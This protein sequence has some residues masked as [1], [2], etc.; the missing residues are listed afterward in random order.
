MERPYNPLSSALVAVHA[1]PPVRAVDKDFMEMIKVYSGEE[2]A[3]YTA[4]FAVAETTTRVLAP[5]V[6]RIQK[7]YRMGDINVISFWVSTKV[8]FKKHIE[9]LF[10]DAVVVDVVI[11]CHTDKVAVEVHYTDTVEQAEE[12]RKKLPYET[13]PKKIPLPMCEDTV[14]K[15]SI[16]QWNQVREVTEHLSDMMKQSVEFSMLYVEDETTVLQTN[17]FTIR[18]AKCDSFIA[19]EGT[20]VAVG[21]GFRATAMRSLL[22]YSFV[23]EIFFSSVPESCYFGINFT[24]PVCRRAGLDKRN[25][26]KMRK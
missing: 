6:C 9:P 25:P 19:P 5:L 1:R 23:K 7:P 13:I 4:S 12:A 10:K 15:F 8:E 22:N 24:M 17:E 21:E 14:L 2:S 11:S 16:D 20:S 26:K 3:R 18:F